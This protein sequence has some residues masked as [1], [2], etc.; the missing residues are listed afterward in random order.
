M[1]RFGTRL[2]IKSYIKCP[3]YIARH[4]PL[5]TD[6]I[7]NGIST[8]LDQVI[9]AISAQSTAL[10]MYSILRNGLLGKEGLSK[11]KMTLV[12][13]YKIGLYRANLTDCMIHIISFSD[14]RN[15]TKGC[16][17]GEVLTL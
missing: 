10:S 13:S 7:E 9:P 6:A 15:A 8:L 16:I 3:V 5:Y 2:E 14:T 4:L 17:Q 1:T 12:H 11:V